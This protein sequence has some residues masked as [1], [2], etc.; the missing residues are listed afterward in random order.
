MHRPH[1]CERP[2]NGGARALL[3]ALLAAAVGACGEAPEAEPA[4]RLVAERLATP[5]ERLHLPLTDF[6]VDVP[7]GTW[8]VAEAE[9]VP[10]QWSLTLLGPAGENRQTVQQGRS[11]AEVVSWPARDEMPKDAMQL[12]ANALALALDAKGYGG[13]GFPSLERLRFLGHDGAEAKIEVGAGGGVMAGFGRLFLP[14]PSHVAFAWILVPREDAEALVRAR[15]FV[16]SLRPREPRFL[17][18]RFYDPAK[19]DDVLV[20]VPGEPPLRREHFAAMERLVEHAMGGPLPVAWREALRTALHRG[21]LIGARAFRD[22]LRES[23]SAFGPELGSEDEVVRQRRLAELGRTFVDSHIARRMEGD[24]SAKPFLIV[25]HQASR[26]LHRYPD[27]DLT[28][29]HV[30]SILEMASFLASLAGDRLLS[31]GAEERTQILERWRDTWADWSRERRARL[32][33]APAVWLR[34]RHAF[35]MAAGAERLAFRRALLEQ[36]LPPERVAGLAGV[37]TAEDLSTFMAAHSG[38]TP[39]DIADRWLDMKAED[40]KALLEALGD[41]G[42]PVPLG[43]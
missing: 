42:N 30:D 31:I 7:A 11:I 25:W 39:T 5:G 18:P 24:E 27:F 17:T 9:P 3:V 38:P 2:P 43:W 33:A 35:D 19:S 8:Y 21:A 37:S 4:P 34:T 36:F 23:V 41:D 28:A 20:E 12:L 1:G 32:Q 22:A 13:H 15:S 6:E 16:E 26:A 29:R 14:T 10:G 40:S